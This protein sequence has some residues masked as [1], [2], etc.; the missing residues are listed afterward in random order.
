MKSWVKRSLLDEQHILGAVFDRLGDGV[1]VSRSELQ[2]AEDQESKVP[3]S[4][5]TRSSVDT[6]GGA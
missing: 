4:S 6:L 2:G 3:W 1:T 5:S